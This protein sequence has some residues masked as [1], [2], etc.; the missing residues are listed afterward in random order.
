MAGKKYS[1]EFMLGAG[2]ESTFA[3]SFNTAT[4]T[5]KEMLDKSNQLNKNRHADTTKG[6]RDDLSRTRQAMQLTENAADR[7][8]GFLLK[9][10]A[11]IGGVAVAYKTF[12]LGKDALNTYGEFEQG[13]A[14][15]KSV[16]G[17]TAEELK[18]LG[19]EA[20]RLGYYSMDS[21]RCNRC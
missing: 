8:R 5:M 3:K 20:K 14:N 11:A 17:A 7:M 9:S 6:V 16:A 12:N 2:L 4:S 1:I 18:L 15:V 13:L 10:F 19:D 21:Q